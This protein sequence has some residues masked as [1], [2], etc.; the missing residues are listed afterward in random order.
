M[1]VLEF[2]K[3]H[4]F[5]GI[6]ADSRKIQ[7]GGLF[8]AFAG[9]TQDGRNYIAQAIANG[10]GGVLWDSAEFNWDTTWAVPNL[11]V[12]NLRQQ[13]SAIASAFYA[14]PSRTLWMIGVTGTNGKT[15]CTQWIAQALTALGKKTAVLGTLGNGLV[16]Q[17]Q[18]TENTTPE[19]IALQGMLAEFVSQKIPAVAMEVSSHGLEQ[20]RVSGLKFDVAVLTNLTQDH[21]DYHG[22]MQSYADAKRQLFDWPHLKYALLNC[23]DPFGAELYAKLRAENKAAFTYG[24]GRDAMIRGD[25]L[26]MDNNGISLHVVSPWGSGTLQAPVY[27][28]FNAYNLLAVL[29]ALLVSDIA[30]ERA[31][32]ALSQIQPVAGRMESYGG[33]S[34]PLVVVDYAHTADALEKVLNALREQTSGKLICVFGCGGN[35]DQ[36]KRGAMGAVATQLSD[37]VIITTD[38]PRFEPPQAIIDA[39]VAGVL[40]QNYRIQTDR[41]AA[42]A[43]AIVGAKAGDVVL[44]AGKGHEDYQEINGQKTPF[45]DSEVVQQVLAG[46][47]NIPQGAGA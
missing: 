16:G 29:G 38:N 41:A 31:L 40:K 39:I 24:F 7:A 21:L 9:E 2:I 10:A 26:L 6:S 30:F 47:A 12:A 15:S 17:L 33:A 43:S 14:E 27:G 20:G 44:V 18:A 34:Q 45:S 3:N 37:E 8:V 46:N 35:R 5:S 23:D 1:D 36:G 4:R 32:K 19:P 28:K 13:V 11:P 22:D 42:I 25:N